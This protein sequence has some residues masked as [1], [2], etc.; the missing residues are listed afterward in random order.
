MADERTQ[1]EQEKLAVEKER[2]YDKAK[3]PRMPGKGIK[4]NDINAKIPYAE[5]QSGKGVE[6]TPK[7]T[8]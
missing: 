3:Q 2:A 1:K 5:D 4:D 7:A 8:P 6:R